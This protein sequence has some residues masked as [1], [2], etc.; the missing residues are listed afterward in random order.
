MLNA[1]LGLLLIT[2]TGPR[3]GQSLDLG[4]QH[5][6]GVLERGLVTLS[7]RF[8][9]D[10]RIGFDAAAG[11][12]MFEHVGV[13]AWGIGARF[14]VLE[15]WDVA[16][17]LAYGH[18][19]WNDWRVGENRAIATLQAR[20][21]GSLELELGLAWRVPLLDPDNFWSPIAWSS[22]IPEWSGVYRLE[23]R[24]LRASGWD[25]SLG[26][27]SYE[28]LRLRNLQHFGF[29]LSGRRRLADGWQLA[30]SLG[31]AVKGLSGLLL[32][33]NEFSAAIGVVHGE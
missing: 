26:T 14:V 29:T 16:A 7:A 28:G 23:W 22:P 13:A 4:W 10:R 8:P 27:A 31:T 2:A 9:T 1:L 5:E 21:V 12:S 24:F 17:R 15:R 3:S 19:Q 11:F 25:L 18:E 30:G 6:S 33:A 20:P 32:S